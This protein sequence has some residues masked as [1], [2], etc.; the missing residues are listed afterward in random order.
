M[1]AVLTWGCHLHLFGRYYQGE[2]PKTTI[3]ET[4]DVEQSQNHDR[5]DS[6]WIVVDPT[7][8]DARPPE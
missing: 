2:E 7:G 6:P 3:V 8:G 1:V 4:P 5:N